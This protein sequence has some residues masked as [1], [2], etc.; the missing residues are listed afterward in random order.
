[1][2]KDPA[3]PSNFTARPMARWAV[4]LGTLMVSAG[5]LYYFL[6]GEDWKNLREA[7]NEAELIPALAAVVIPHLVF[8]LTDAAFTVRSFQWFHRP[9]GFR[10]YLVIKAGAYLLTMVN[11]SISAGMVFYYFTRKTKITVK[12]QAGLLL[13]RVLVAV[14]GYALLFSAFLVA[15]LVLDYRLVAGVNIAAAA[16]LLVLS[17]LF[18]ADFF[19][20][21]RTGR[22]LAAKKITAAGEF[23]S[24]FRESTLSHWVKGWGYTAPALVVDFLGMYVVAWAFDV[25]VP[26]VYFMTW[27]PLVAVLSAL[28]IAFGGLGTTTAA[29]MVFFSAYADPTNIAAATIFLPGVRVIARALMGLVFLPAAMQELAGGSDQG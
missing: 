14:T 5:L 16:P 6:R 2:E 26:F 25:H 23:F 24:S 8:W 13:W 15:A 4:R 20:H 27:I 19:I 28:P 17:L 9:V 21:K 22:S 29:W 12:K 18:L 10:N 1:M 3:Q 11:I 7:A